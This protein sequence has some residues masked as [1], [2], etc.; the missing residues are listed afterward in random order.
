VARQCDEIRERLEDN[1]INR[2]AFAQAVGLAAAGA[3]VVAACG[4][5]PR[6]VPTEPEMRT[7]FRSTRHPAARLAV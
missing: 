3:S 4:P 2:R 5:T 6:T 7:T 1:M